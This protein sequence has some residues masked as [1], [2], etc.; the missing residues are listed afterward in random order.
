MSKG[1]CIIGDDCRCVSEPALCSNW[2]VETKV[3][4]RGPNDLPAEL[5]EVVAGII[6]PQSRAFYTGSD[7]RL[8]ADAM[9]KDAIRATLSWVRENV[10]EEMMF[11][12]GDVLGA[13]NAA[14]VSLHPKIIK[15]AIRAAFDAMEGKSDE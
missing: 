3:V 14:Q 6:H 9:A 2:K 15:D 4:S 1:Y 5:V 11:A 8:V 13:S 7:V 12:A 10:S